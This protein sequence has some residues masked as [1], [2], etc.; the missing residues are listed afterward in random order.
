MKMQDY[1]DR[2]D[3]KLGMKYGR[4]T[5]MKQSYKDRRD[6]SKG[7]SKIEDNMHEKKPSKVMPKI[8]QGFSEVK[9]FKCGHK[10][11]PKQAYDYKY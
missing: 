1:N 5:S 8:G 7:M 10:G 2:L 3:E 4:E 6:E 11:Y 9:D